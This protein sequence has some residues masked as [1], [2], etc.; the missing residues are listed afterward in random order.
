MI[1]MFLMGSLAYAQKD[2]TTI[3]KKRVLESTEIDILSSYY[4]QTGDNASVTGGIGNE[5]LTD[6]TPTIIVSMPLNADDVLTIDAGFSTYTSASSSNVNPFDK[7]GASS[8]TNNTMEGSPWVASSGASQKDTW[9]N[10]SV[11]YAHSSD[12]RNKKWSTNISFSNEYDYSSIGIGGAYTLQFNQKNTEMG[13]SSNLF[14]DTWKAVYPTELKAYID[15]EGDLDDGFFSNADILDINGNITPKSG[16]TWN[17]D[18]FEKIKDKGRNTYAVSLSF[19]QILGKNAQFSLF[20]DIVMQKGYLANPM[21]RV[22]FADKA[23]Y[24]IGNAS[25]IPIYTSSENRDV[26]MLAD[27]IERLPDTR[28]KIPV[29]ARFNYYFNEF[30]TLRT[31]Y[32]YYKDDWGIQSN[33]ISVE[34][35]IKI[36]GKLTLYPGYRFYNQSTADYFAPFDAHLSTDEYYT[37]D[38]DLSKFDANQW[39]IGLTYTDIFTSFH[40]GK[41]G[42]KSIDLK[43]NNYE[44]N[45]G[46]KANYFAFGLKFVMD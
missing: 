13:L 1:L 32:R 34:L 37:S 29:G 28:F 44:R 10:L 19:S 43:Y 30:L 8:N 7:S 23:N 21:Q 14:F 9:T 3:Y 35:P 36:L 6:F 4:K 33:T 24:F 11:S 46:L 15:E 2:S 17:P 38:Y 5:E 18:A 40:I 26:F 31:Y 20:A 22:Y 39:S 16:N 25:S 41:F 27:D 45:S 12:D 42:L